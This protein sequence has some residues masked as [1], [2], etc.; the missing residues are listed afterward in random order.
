MVKWCVQGT[1][2]LWCYSW[3]LVLFLAPRLPGDE[4]R[5]KQRGNPVLFKHKSE[6]LGVPQLLNDS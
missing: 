3:V 5:K 1:Y 2:V 6:G 4:K